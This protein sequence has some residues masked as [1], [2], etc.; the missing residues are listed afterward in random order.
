[1]TN[2]L[3]LKFEEMC[4]IEKQYS[5]ANGKPRPTLHQVDEKETG[6]TRRK[7]VSKYMNMDT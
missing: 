5:M 6:K 7:S 2:E 1:M 4:A 3:P